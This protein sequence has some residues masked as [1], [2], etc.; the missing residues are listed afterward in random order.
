MQ[1]GPGSDATTAPNRPDPT[2][3]PEP[4]A[5]AP[6]PTAHEPNAELR[7]TDERRRGEDRLY[8]GP[9]PGAQP[10]PTVDR[11]P[12]EGAR[13]DH[14]LRP[15]G[16][17]DGP[18]RVDHRRIPPGPFGSVVVGRGEGHDLHGDTPTVPGCYRTD[19]RLPDL[20]RQRL[21][22]GRPTVV[23]PHPRLRRRDASR[24]RLPGCRRRLQPHHPPP[25]SVA[26][27]E[28]RV[29]EGYQPEVDEPVREGTPGGHA[30]DGDHHPRATHAGLPDRHRRPPDRSP[31]PTSSRPPRTASRSS[32][33]GTSLAC[34][35]RPT[36]TRRSRASPPRAT[37]PTRFRERTPTSVPSLTPAPRG[38]PTPSASLPPTTAPGRTPCRTPAPPRS[39]GEKAAASEAPSPDPA[40]FWPR[41]RIP[42]GRDAMI[43]YDT[44]GRGAPPPRG[45]PPHPPPVARSQ[46]T[47]ASRFTSVA[48]T[49]PPNFPGRPA[50][51][52]ATV[53]STPTAGRSRACRIT[54]ATTPRISLDRAHGDSPTHRGTP[55]AAPS[56][57]PPPPP[58]HLPSPRGPTPTTTSPTTE[59]RRRRILPPHRPAT[60]RGTTT[61]GPPPSWSRRLRRTTPPSTI[62]P[63]N[64]GPREERPTSSPP[65]CTPRTPRPPPDPPMVPPTTG[66]HSCC[67]RTPCGRL[68]IADRPTGRWPHGP[69]GDF[70][71]GSPQPQAGDLGHLAKIRTADEDMTVLETFTVARPSVEERL[72]AGKALRT[73]VPR[74]EHARFDTNP[75]RPDPITILEPARCHRR[76]PSWP[77]PPRDILIGVTLQ[78]L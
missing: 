74:A 50:I 53:G 47:A 30:G 32:W 3:N 49:I 51:R 16:L 75:D 69:E 66:A 13:D 10:S 8:R 36:R 20:P 54:S 7:E 40:S 35:H 4:G 52:R 1:A 42:R 56:A 29:L 28:Q 21:A 12:C 18:R 65:S 24:R 41:G 76:S 45:G 25:S 57:P 78:N 44:R 34:P 38:P 11:S 71:M 67:G 33:A 64:N 26:P 17:L 59:G 14:L 31:A 62:P 58:R 22:G 60:R 9:A 27:D 72:A 63:T 43:N 2:P 73:R 77:P 46:T 39:A 37:T 6:A 15:P 19:G 70:R 61:G 48:S 23:P 5:R 68:S 55:R